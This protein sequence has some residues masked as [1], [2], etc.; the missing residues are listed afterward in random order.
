MTD[1]KMTEPDS[2]V[3]KA[4]DL[5]TLTHKQFNFVKGILEGK[6]ASDAYRDAYDA[7]NMSDAVIWVKAS[8]LK[9]SGTVSVWLVEAREQALTSAIMTKEAYIRELWADRVKMEKDHPALSLKALELAGKVMGHYVDRVE[10]DVNAKVEKIER[11][12][13]DAPPVKVAI[14]ND[15]TQPDVTHV[16]PIRR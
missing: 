6:T 10:V 9:S 12:I 1:E 8:E 14:E 13:V 7:E 5:P 16:L 4:D 15:E 11:V 2:I 3:E